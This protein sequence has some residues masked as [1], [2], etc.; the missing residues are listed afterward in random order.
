MDLCYGHE[1]WLV[2]RTQG[3][4]QGRTGGGDEEG[5]R[6]RQMQGGGPNDTSFGPQVHFLLFVYPLTM[7]FLQLGS[8]LTAHG[9][10]TYPVPQQQ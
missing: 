10:D 3:E 5:E 9:V 1:Q 8:T 2:G 6:E 7:C 4:E